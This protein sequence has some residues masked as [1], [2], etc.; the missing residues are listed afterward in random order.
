MSQ[1]VASRLSPD[2][3]MDVGA[4]SDAVPRTPLPFRVWGCRGL[5]TLLIAGCVQAL[6]IYYPRVLILLGPQELGLI[7]S[8]Q[9]PREIHTYIHTYIHTRVANKI[10]I[11]ILDYLHPS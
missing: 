3:A 11:S 2:A 1:D 5:A 6:L 10:R 4:N 9:N 8:Q 7:R